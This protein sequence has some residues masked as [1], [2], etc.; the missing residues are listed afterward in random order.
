[1]R[2]PESNSQVYLYSKVLQRVMQLVNVMGLLAQANDHTKN[3]LA[4]IQRLNPTDQH[5]AVLVRFF[6]VTSCGPKVNIQTRPTISCI[7]QHAAKR[8]LE[9][10]SCKPVTSVMGY[11]P[12]S[13]SPSPPQTYPGQALPHVPVSACY[14]HLTSI[15]KMRFPSEIILEWLMRIF[16]ISASGKTA[17]C[18]YLI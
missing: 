9:P 16:W 2:A 14:L 15:L 12:V 3:R 11:W 6:I 8:R 17:W 7:C 5:L 18:L 13:P 1:M 10:G 4:T